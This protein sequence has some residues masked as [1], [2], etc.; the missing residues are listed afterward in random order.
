MQPQAV[1]AWHDFLTTTARVL[2]VDQDS[3]TENPLARCL[4]LAGFHVETSDDAHCAVQ[5]ATFLPTVVILGPRLSRATRLGLCS[6]IRALSQVPFIIVS[7][8][9]CEDD[10]VSC[11]DAGADDYA[12]TP[13][14]PGEIIARTRA[15]QRL[16]ARKHR[17]ALWC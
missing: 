16:V 10:V 17:A 1:S 13:Y 7:G 15:G 6:R 9:G 5:V 14:T 3:T 8:P 12:T 4:A 11:L 2:V